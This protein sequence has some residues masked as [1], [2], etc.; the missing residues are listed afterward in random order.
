LPFLAALLLAS[1]H[2]LPSIA[3][4]RLASLHL[5]SH[6]LAA[7]C[8]STCLA[9]SRLDSHL[10][11]PRLTPCLAYVDCRPT[12]PCLCCLPLISPFLASRLVLPR[13][14]LPRLTP[15][16]VLARTALPLLTFPRLASPC[17]SPRLDSRVP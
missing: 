3:S 1:R 4:P 5:T 15:H 6:R 11:V 9:S 2:A 8:F 12:S 17:L 16:Y 10:P 14:D 13:L 7:L